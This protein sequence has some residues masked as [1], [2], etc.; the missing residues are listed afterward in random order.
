MRTEKTKAADFFDVS[1]VEGERPDGV[2][3]LGGGVNT[4]LEF[5]N[6]QSK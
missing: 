5:L 6:K 4:F 3:V 2:T 1:N